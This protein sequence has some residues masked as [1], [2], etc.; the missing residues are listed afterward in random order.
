MADDEEFRFETRSI[1][2]GQDPDEE[3]GAL[4][5]PIHAN[6]TYEQDAPG[7]HRGYEYSRTGNPTRTDLEA[8]VASLE[9]GEYGRAFSS[10]MGA[11]NTVLNLLESGDHVVASEDVYGG[12]HRIFTQVY[13]QYDLQFDFVDMTDLDE[14]EAAMRENTELVWVETPTNPLLNV[15]DIASTAEI[16][17]DNDALCAV[18]NTFATPYLQRPLDLGA[19]LVT[20]SLTKYMGGHSDV[21]G[22]A[23][24]TDDEEL[25]ERF[26][27][28]QNSVGATPGPH[29]C[30][31]VLRGTKTLPVRM[32][33]HCENAIELA[34]WLEDHEDVSRVYYPGLDS[35]PDHDLAASQ[36]DDFGGMVSF[37]MDASLE[38]TA[39]VVSNTEVFTLAESLGGVE[40][41]IEQPATMTH[42][43]IPAEER[44]AAGLRDGLIRASV[45]I[46]NV[47]DLKADLAQAFEQSLN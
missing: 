30:F 1:H 31:L 23:L 16:A 32:D 7:E 11:I 2:A 40:S 36:M 22:G 47:E 45:G 28:Y 37:E 20:H 8:N 10:G 26:G 35:H 24:V 17:H 4:M 3:T 27:F 39:D 19:D 34:E 41:L 9:G 25:D 6:S 15:V 38:E 13:E 14:T 5:T 18:D 12:T 43:A 42:A 46:E 29:E 21:V 44:E 33:R